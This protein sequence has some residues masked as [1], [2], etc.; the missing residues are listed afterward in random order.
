VLLRCGLATTVMD[1]PGLAAIGVV[2]M[3]YAADVSVHPDPA[4]HVGDDVAADA[5]QALTNSETHD[6]RFGFYESHSVGG[7]RMMDPV[8]GT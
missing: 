2:P 5:R 6:G 1:E 4:A 3:S 8:Q 7:G